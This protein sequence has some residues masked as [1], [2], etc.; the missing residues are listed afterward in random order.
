MSPL[1]VSLPV[2]ISECAVRQCSC[3]HSPAQWTPEPLLPCNRDF[4][5]SD[6]SL[7]S[8]VQRS[9]DSLSFVVRKIHSTSGF[10]VFV[11]VLGNMLHWKKMEV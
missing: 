4:V 10:F 9:K 11:F 7:P 5:S 6:R 1:S 8:P 2:V 3:G